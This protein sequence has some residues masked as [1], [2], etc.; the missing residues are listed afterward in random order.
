MSIKPS[1]HLEKDMNIL[2][3]SKQIIV[4][5]QTPKIAA[6]EMASIGEDLIIAAYG[7]GNIPSL[8]LQN[9]ETGELSKIK[10]DN[11]EG[12]K[13]WCAELNCDSIKVCL[14]K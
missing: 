11:F 5:E 3:K 9:Q 7:D 1:L 8:I 10:L 13:I 2:Q 6:I 12:Y 14:V 4:K